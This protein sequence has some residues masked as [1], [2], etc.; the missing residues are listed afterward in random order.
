MHSPHTTEASL[1]LQLVGTL[2][3][4]KPELLGH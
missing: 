3:T 2:A 4:V 1:L